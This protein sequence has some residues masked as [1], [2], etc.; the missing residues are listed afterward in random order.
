MVLWY[1]DD[2]CLLIGSNFVSKPYKCSDISH[3]VTK[4]STP[5][6]THKGESTMTASKMSYA[7]GDI[8]V[9]LLEV[10]TYSCII[11]RY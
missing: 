3:K 10:P 5:P 11:G 2:T 1:I 4:S 8:G 7:A 9:S 6:E